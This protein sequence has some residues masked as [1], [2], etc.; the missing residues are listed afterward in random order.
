MRRTAGSRGVCSASWAGA[1]LCL[2]LWPSLAPVAN[3]VSQHFLLSTE[4]ISWLSLA[5]LVVSIP[6]GVVAI[7]VLDSAGLRWVVSRTPHR[8]PLWDGW[9]PRVWAREPSPPP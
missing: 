3:T 6:F 7:W 2:Q 8:G 9:G 5:Y 4:Q 1:G